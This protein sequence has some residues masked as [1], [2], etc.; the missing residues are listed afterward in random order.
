MT[1]DRRQEERRRQR[2]A[3]QQQR[4]QGRT[5]RT[6]L[7]PGSV[8]FGGFMGWMQRNTR[9]LFLGAILIFVMSLGAGSLLTPA[10]PTPTATPAPSDTPTPVASATTTATASPTSTPDPSIQRKYSAAPPM[11][12]DQTKA[13]TAVIAL[14]S[15][16]EVRIA[17]LPKD[18]PQ[19]VNNFVYL[20][21]N[22]FFDGLTF[23]RVIPGFVAQGGDP[24]GSGFGG[25]G[26]AVPLDRNTL[27]FDTGVI[28]MAKAGNASVTSGSQFFITLAPTPT[29]L[30]GFAVF[31]RVTQGMDV[32]QKITP[33]DPEKATTQGDIIASIK[34]IE[35]N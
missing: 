15:G 24:D 2:L 18:A 14:K 11:S 4:R 10:T 30:G 26:Y 29:L 12:I 7:A 5:S 32:V 23:H 8:E 27:P 35:G 16:G 1:Q 19:A 17:L 33:R 9:W 34:I 25:P 31:G 13:Y 20:A 6:D 28:A 21:K 3:K 22:R